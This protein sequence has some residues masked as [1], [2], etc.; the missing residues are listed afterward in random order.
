MFDAGRVLTATHVV[1]GYESP[2]IEVYTFDVRWDNERLVNVV[3]YDA[4]ADVAVLVIDEYELPVDRLWLAPGRMDVGEW[5]VVGYPYEILTLKTGAVVSHDWPDPNLTT[6]PVWTTDTDTGPGSPG[7]PVFN[8]WGEV[9]G[10]NIGWVNTQNTFGAVL[11]IGDVMDL[12]SEWDEGGGDE[13]R[14][15]DEDVDEDEPEDM[16]DMDNLDADD[17]D[18]D[19]DD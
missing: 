16:G 4:A 2:D 8:L 6:L 11:P 17:E 3:R 15:V 13:M 9:V 19:E 1:V 5:A 7:A 12:I 18:V 10:I 14:R